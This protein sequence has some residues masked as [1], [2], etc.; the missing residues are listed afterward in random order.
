VFEFSEQGRKPCEIVSFRVGASVPPE[1]LPALS[2]E[3][4]A[5]SDGQHSIEVF[6][7][8]QW[9]SCKR[10]ARSALTSTGAAGPALVEDVTST[11]FVPPGWVARTD[12]ADNVLM[13]QGRG[14]GS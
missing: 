4:H 14:E 11:L 5:A 12:T 9:Q 2:G 13:K 10:L 3:Q 1:E 7:Q 6:E 8:G